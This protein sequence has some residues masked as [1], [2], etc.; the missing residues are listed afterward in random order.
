MKSVPVAE[1]GEM[2][3]GE[4]LLRLVCK[5]MALCVA[6]FGAVGLLILGLQ[7]IL[8]MLGRGAYVETALAT[9]ACVAVVYGLSPLAVEVD[10]ALLRL[11]GGLEP[12]P[13]S[14]DPKR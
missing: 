4:W 3:V 9:I 14:E 6:I 2:G 8:P 13:A 10:N 12:L 1:K 5:L 11:C 7:S